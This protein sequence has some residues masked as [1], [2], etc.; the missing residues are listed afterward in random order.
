MFKSQYLTITNLN[1]IHI[2]A[3]HYLLKNINL[4]FQPGWTGVIGAN[5]TGKTTLL[6]L[7]NGNLEPK[8][9]QILNNSSSI[10]CEQRMDSYSE[11]IEDFMYAYDSHACKLRSRFNINESWIDHWGTLSFGERKR[12]QI[13]SAIWSN[14]SLLIVDE[15]TNHLDNRSKN[16]LFQLLQ[17]FTG[18]GILVSHDRT[19]IDELCQ[20]TVFIDPPNATMYKGGHTQ[21]IQQKEVE[22]S[23]IRNEI[24]V[25]R[26]NYMK[27]KKEHSK[28]KHEASLADAKRSKRKLAPKDNDGRSKIR[29]AIVTGRDGN[30]GKLQSQIEGRLNQYLDKLKKMKVKKISE[31]GIWVEESS[32]HKNTLINLSQAQMQ[33]HEKLSLDIPDLITTPNDKIALTGNNGTGKTS[34]IKIIL[35]KMQLEQQKVLYIPQ[36]VSID[37]SINIL[38]KAKS[39]NNVKLGQIM[40]IVNRLGSEPA[41]LFETSLPSPGEIRKLYIALGILKAPDLIIMDEPTNH[42]DLP[43]IECLEEALKECPCALLLVSHDYSFLKKLTEIRWHIDKTGENESTLTKKFWN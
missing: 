25:A 17:M 23:K 4:T 13:A 2:G 15:P 14:P 42:L 10:F 35:E 24:K 19:F 26:S 36:E 9:G 34:L 3:S 31:L 11:L 30:A 20:N 21:S 41:R 39:L 38:A 1:F 8:T 5:G 29:A 7:I 27:L 43:S 22:E 32:S 6:K 37:E 33:I 16:Y 18:T 28:R 12:T 40:S